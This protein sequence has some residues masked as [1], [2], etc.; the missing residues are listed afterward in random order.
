MIDKKEAKRKY[1]E[2]L[3]PMGIYQ[4]KNLAN[5]KVLIGYSKNLH[6]KSNSYKFQLN[7]GTHINNELQT[8]YNKFGE[9]NF[10]FEVLD[11]LDPKE[12]VNYDYTKDLEAL[13]EL[14]IEKIQ[15]FG[16]KGYNKNQKYSV[17]Q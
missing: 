15:P 14:W 5:N 12:G 16:D 7:A 3:P 10:V 4:V 13:E 11:Y 1:K 2:T 17:E 6:G 8:E 9:E